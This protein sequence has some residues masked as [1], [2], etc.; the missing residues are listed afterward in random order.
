[1]ENTE[2]FLAVQEGLFEEIRQKLPQHQSLVSVISD[3]FGLGLDAA[4]KR[5]RGDKRLDLDEICALCKRY[6]VS[7]DQIM[8]VKY[9]HDFDCK[10][11]PINSSVPIEYHDYI[12]SLSENFKKLRHSK[13]SSILLSATDIP[14]FHLLPH[15]EL[16]FFKLFTF[17]HGV[18][19][20]KESWEKFI[21]EM[22]TKEIEDKHKIISRDYE[23]IPSTE[24]WTE[25]TIDSTLKLIKY[26]HD[27][28][29][30][31][32]VELPMLLCEQVLSILNNLESWATKSQKNDCDTPFTLY[33]SEMEIG[34]TYILLKNP[35]GDNCIVK[36]FTINH[37]DISDKEFCKEAEDWLTKLSRRS[38]LLCGG[39]EK[40][41]IQ[42]FN[43]QRR[44]VQSVIDSILTHFDTP[45]E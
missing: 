25:S 31:P 7:F 34:N 2:N 14:V 12:N 24:I 38:L 18:Y 11:R 26:Y 44:K 8:D 28:S 42:F 36:L 21:S 15:K 1:M 41:R 30:F 27:I 19:N 5:I 20:Y 37:L 45:L 40:E 33:L 29:V 9:P 17:A 13:E 23:L 4:Y 6:K 39:S 22:S 35:I 16:R 3:M 10:Y 43:L 32:D